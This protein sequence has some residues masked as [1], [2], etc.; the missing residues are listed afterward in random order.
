M[1]EETGEVLSIGGEGV[2]VQTI[3]QSSCSSCSAAKGCGQKLLASVGQG[4]RFEVLAENSLELNLRTGDQVILGL[5]ESALLQ[6]SMLAY[7]LPLLALA[8]FAGVAQWLGATEHLVIITGIVGLGAGLL[9]TKWRVSS[10]ASEQYQ[11]QILRV[12]P[13]S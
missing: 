2:R 11:P 6:A 9:L 5:A 12:V 4:Q 7:M 1:L 10:A 3:R 8:A 13:K